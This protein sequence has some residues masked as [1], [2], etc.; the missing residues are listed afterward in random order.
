MWNSRN[1]TSCEAIPQFHTYVSIYG[2][3]IFP[4]GGYISKSVGMYLPHAKE[5]W[6]LT[7]FFHNKEVL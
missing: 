6:K 4:G 7:D 5:N 1:C 2:Y 3:N